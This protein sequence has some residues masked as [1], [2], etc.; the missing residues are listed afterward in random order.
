MLLPAWLPVRPHM[1]R[2]KLD[3]CGE[4]STVS[5]IR[6]GLCKVDLSMHNFVEFISLYQSR[7]EENIVVLRIFKYRL[8]LF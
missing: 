7:N 6:H 3:K 8:N 4:D 5:Y 1:P 2:H